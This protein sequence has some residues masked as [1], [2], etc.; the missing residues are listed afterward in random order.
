MK[1]RV[2]EETN[3]V[4]NNDRI[5]TNLIF[6]FEEINNNSISKTIAK[7][8]AKGILPTCIVKYFS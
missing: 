7:A 3:D 4:Q 8:K 2:K 5:S 1:E 6:Y